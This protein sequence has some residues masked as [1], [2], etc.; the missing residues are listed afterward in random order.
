M[1][2]RADE[3]PLLRPPEREPDRHGGCRLLCQP[4]RRRIALYINLDM[5]GSPNFARFIHVIE[6][7]KTDLA[8]GAVQALKGHFAERNLATE[9]RTGYRRGFGS[10][11]ASFA[12][13]GVPTI[14]LFTGASGAKN[15]AQAERFGG[16]AEKPFDPCY[17]QACD[18]TGNVD[19]Q[20]L[21]QITDAVTE[22]L[23][24]LPAPQPSGQ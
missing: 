7:T 10:D 12:A 5:V 18:T 14:G 13:A 8:T 11:D 6:D 20:V 4:Q 24:R 9:E 3:A 15:A 19:P 22:V 23:R 1:V 2:P 16:T 21:G 17:H